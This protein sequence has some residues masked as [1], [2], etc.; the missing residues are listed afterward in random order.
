MSI[1]TFQNLKP[2]LSPG[3]HRFTVHHPPA[4]QWGYAMVICERCGMTRE[5]AKS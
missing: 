4:G 5:E 2:C 1:P 3:A